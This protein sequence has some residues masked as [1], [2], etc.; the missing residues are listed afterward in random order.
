ML[1][2]RNAG[3]ALAALSLVVF[4]GESMASTVMGVPTNW[5]L[6]NYPGDVVVLWFTGAV[7]CN[8]GRLALPNG[9]KDDINRLWSLVL[10]AKL[11]K[12]V[13]SIEY[14]GSGDSCTI[15]SFHIDS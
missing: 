15:V 12:Q 10:S 8:N 5:R 6:E 4:P 7:G 9:T 11:S 3:A 2:I 1:R 13:I 14:G